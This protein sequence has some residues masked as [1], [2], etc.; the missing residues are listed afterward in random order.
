MEI[1]KKLSEMIEEELD[2]AEKYAKCAVVHKEDHPE[3]A[4]VF[5]E[6]SVSETEHYRKL[7][8]QVV[9]LI[10]E[11]RERSGE[12]PRTMR[13]IY[14]FLHERHIEKAKEVKMLQHQYSGS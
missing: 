11:E 3:L 7:H 8:E 14:D 10:H 4:K 2:D 6:L 9:E 5:Y 13:A 1:I 12:P